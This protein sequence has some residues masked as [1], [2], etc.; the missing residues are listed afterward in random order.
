MYEVTR[1]LSAIEQGDSHAARVPM[2]PGDRVDSLSLSQK[3]FTV[4]HAIF[5]WFYSRAGPDFAGGPPT[6]QSNT[7]PI[8]PVAKVRPSGL[9]QHAAWVNPG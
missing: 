7:R 5:F 1:I 2:R 6:S 9:K 3:T 8:P 4:P